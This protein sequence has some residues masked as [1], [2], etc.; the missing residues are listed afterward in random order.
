MNRREAVAGLV[1]AGFAPALLAR[2]AAAQV[3]K[4]LRIGYQKN[5]VLV[6]ARRQAV[7]E[8]RLD[9][10]GVG[11]EWVEFPAGPPLLEAMTAGEIDLGQVGDTPPIFAQAAG[12]PIVYV[13]GQSITNGQ[14]ILVRS[15]SD[16]TALSGLKGERIGFTKGSSAH[17]VVLLALEKAGLTYGDIVPVYLSPGDAA[18]AFARR[19]IDAWAVW[20]PYY[21]IG[22]KVGGGRV[23]VH[24]SALGKT[25][26]FY[27]ANRAF[28]ARESLLLRSVLDTLGETAQWAEAHRDDVAKALADVT[29]VDLAIQTIAAQRSSFAIGKLTDDI[30]TTQQGVA[31]RFFKLGLIPRPIVIREAIW[32]APQS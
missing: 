11:V 10:D 26:A 29:G 4:K 9:R 15:D 12:A 19:S 16:I 1:L 31:D 17:N 28:A 6:I 14:G 7:L 5:G 27:I 24:A 21:A 32:T 2:R 8:K 18:A 23:L 20:D 22:E 3:S 25:N 30:I 13:A